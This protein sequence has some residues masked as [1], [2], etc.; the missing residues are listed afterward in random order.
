MIIKNAIKSLITGSGALRGLSRIQGPSLTVLRYHSVQNNPA[1]YEDTIGSSIIHSTENFRN[2]M[3]LVS[4]HYSPISMDDVI[5]YLE[6]DFTLPPYPVVITFDDGY[7]DNLEIA[8]PILGEFNIPATFY[9]VMNSVAD[10]ETNSIWFMRIRKAFSITKKS[11]WTDNNS[12]IYPLSDE[13]NKIKARGAAMAYCGSTIGKTQLEH[14]AQIEQALDVPAFETDSNIMLTWDDIR[15]LRDQGHIIGSHT[16]THPN[17]AYVKEEDAKFE[18]DQSRLKLENKIG[19]SV[20]HFSYPNPILKPNWNKKTYQL[21]Q[22]SEYKTAVT[23]D[24]GCI[25]FGDDPLTL[26]RLSSPQNPDE[27]RWYVE[28]T[29]NGFIL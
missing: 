17:L 26:K 15:Q 21:L 14:V 28:N 7:K 10:Q 4:R 19:E 13:A 29:M 5:N 1:N 20:S 23:C 9:I 24:N 16:M 12:R 11:S 27:L 2:Q 18:I 8:A 25:R 6:G 3:R 22:N